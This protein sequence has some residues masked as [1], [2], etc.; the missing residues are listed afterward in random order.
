MQQ[1]I[2]DWMSNQA[3]QV[4]HSADGSIALRQVAEPDPATDQAVLQV[5]HVSANFGEL[6]F[7]PS[8]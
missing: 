5:A 3:L 8:A 6:R 7:V 2:G 1:T 4:D